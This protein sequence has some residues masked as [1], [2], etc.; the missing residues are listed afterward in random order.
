MIEQKQLNH[1]A[2][3][4]D[5]TSLNPGDTPIQI[6]EL[7]S[8]AMT[9]KVA[10]I[11]IYSHFIPLAKQIFNQAQITTIKLATVVNFPTPLNDLDK[12]L[13]E[14]ELALKRGANEIDI[15]LPYYSLQQSDIKSVAQMLKQAKALCP[16]KIVKVI[17]ESGVLKDEKL[18]TQASNIVIESGCDF[19]KTSTGFACEHATLKASE[20]ILRTIKASNKACGFKAS[21]GIKTTALALNYIK[22]ASEIM[23]EPWVNNNNF[24]FGASSLLN[25]II[26]KRTST[27][28]NY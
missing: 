14:I 1:L 19:I 16:D 18:I 27:S 6:E 28:N 26:N 13:M 11:C 10:A 2:S 9:Y 7:C 15:V 12:S 17:I 3:L 4:I 20:I 25:D 5:L 23:G 24:R 22:L 8:L 21:G